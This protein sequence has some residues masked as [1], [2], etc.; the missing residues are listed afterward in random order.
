MV[1]GIELVASFHD[2]RV[3][4]TAMIKLFDGDIEKHGVR[5][6]VGVDCGKMES[7]REEVISEQRV[8]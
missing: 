5:K 8:Q 4:D 2:R 3:A 7:G 1:G 6:A